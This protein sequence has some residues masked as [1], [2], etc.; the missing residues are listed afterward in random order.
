MGMPPYKPQYKPARPIQAS[1]DLEIM[2]IIQR[3][4]PKMHR[5]TNAETHAKKLQPSSKTVHTITHIS[6][7]FYIFSKLFPKKFCTE[8]LGY[9][10]T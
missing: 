1:N 8:L 3:S 6:A 5:K 10:A 2:E 4:V 7:I 9:L